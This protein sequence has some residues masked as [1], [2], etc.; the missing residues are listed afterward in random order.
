MSKVKDS[1]I[2]LVDYQ[3]KAV[4][5]AVKEVQVILD[6]PKRA[7]ETR[8]F[9]LQAPTGSGK[10]IMSSSIVRG[11]ADLENRDFAFVFIAPNT[12]HTQS[13]ASFEQH[14]KGENVTF[15]DTLPGGAL[16]K[17]SILFLNWASVNKAKNKMI[18]ARED[19]RTIT[20]VMSKTREAGREI[21]L[22]IDES[23]H[24]AGSAISQE[25]IANVSPRV[26]F[27]ITATPKNL[28]ST[29]DMLDKVAAWV[30]VDRKDVIDSGMICKSA[31]FGQDYDRHEKSYFA[32]FGG[33]NAD[34]N[35]LYVWAALQERLNFEA[36]LRAENANFIPAYVPAVGIQLPSEGKAEL[37]SK[38]ELSKVDELIAFL[39]KCGVQSEE[40]AVYLSGRKENMDDKNMPN[41]DVKV[42]IF[43]TAIAVGWD[44]PR[45]KVGALLRDTKT[46]SFAVQTLGRWMR[47]PE[48][49]QHADEYLNSAY[50]YTDVALMPAAAN[51]D[52]D[53]TIAKSVVMREKFKKSASALKLTSVNRV[54]SEH[55]VLDTQYFAKNWMPLLREEW[56]N[57]PSFY[58]AAPV[59][60]NDAPELN[61]AEIFEQMKFTTIN[62]ELGAEKEINSGTITDIDAVDG[63]V[64]S[65]F[66]QGSASISRKLSYAETQAEFEKAVTAV[67]TQ[68]GVSNAAN[69]INLILTCI[70]R[71]TRLDVRSVARIIIKSEGLLEVFLTVVEKVATK[72][73]LENTA[74]F[75]GGTF[76][77]V[78]W[79]PKET[80][81]LLYTKN[82]KTG[83]SVN[84]PVKME[85]DS[86]YLYDFAPALGKNTGNSSD[87]EKEYFEFLES[88]A[89]NG[90]V[91]W[92]VKNGDQGSEFFSFLYEKPVAGAGTEKALFYPDWII[93]RAD[94]SID[95]HDTKK[96]N[97]MSDF[98]TLAK[99][100]AAVAYSE[101][102]TKERG[103]TVNSAMVMSKIG[104]GG[105]TEFRKS[106]KTATN[107]VEDDASNWEPI[108]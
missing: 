29:Q 66:R 16:E 96:G 55:V 37:D 85:D 47:Q 1:M 68:S 7:D 26:I 19:A 8:K 57:N 99:Q 17:N 51:G 73:K 45:L 28:F 39:L 70:A 87:I 13:K 100:K 56:K 77:E 92:F 21:I 82:Q 63:S 41:E 62:D 49:K 79:T 80:A 11:L 75:Q 76:E 5:E 69:I 27:D 61:V 97:T 72:F 54:S 4:K 2:V 34:P 14:L 46:K 40:I 48:R 103:I 78:I 10:T 88:S 30:Q 58:P 89:A 18:A 36:H 101:K 25:F 43:K 94:G 53:V 81:T 86:R 60:G 23:H 107:L 6:S 90:E 65:A 15:L 24:S 31:V 64:E 35:E 59:P 91:E 105:K 71:I 44:F 67:L 42:V 104:V 20:D 38:D 74:L 22:I 3:D 106:K 52:I 84:E 102:L 108:F 98:A 12:L 93:C 32:K 33:I 83:K 50:F 9:L 95:L